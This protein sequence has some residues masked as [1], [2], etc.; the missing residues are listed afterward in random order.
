[1]INLDVVRSPADLPGDFLQLDLTNTGEV[2]D[3][4]AQ[5]RPEGMCQLSANPSPFGFPRHQTFDSYTVGRVVRTHAAHFTGHTWQ[6]K[7][8]RG[9]YSR[10]FGADKRMFDPM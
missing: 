2:Y 1:M 10:A 7:D 3:V 6:V 4:V 5:L 8:V 9:V